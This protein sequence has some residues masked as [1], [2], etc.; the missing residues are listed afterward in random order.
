MSVAGDLVDLLLPVRCL[1]CGDRVPEGGRR[2]PVCARCTARIR[3]L[4]SPRC[5]RCDLPRGTR[6][7]GG[8]ACPHCAEWPP[9]LVRARCLTALAPPTDDLLH[10]LKYEGW[11]VVAAVLGRRLAHLAPKADAVVAVPTTPE[12]E[13]S[14]GYNQAALLAHEV[15]LARGIPRLDAL[16]RRAGRGS[17]IALQAAD[18]RAN[19]EDA[20]AP[21]PAARRLPDTDHVILVDDVLT[22][23]ATASAAASALGGLGVRSVT[24]LAVARTL[25][26]APDGLSAA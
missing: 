19:V 16:T 15:A 7:S 26:R 23:G 18:R 1:G 3:P 12:R 25:P 6:R 21:G 5:P 8:P 17:Q 2:G 14:R 9:V 11:P 22:T 20:F 4:P 10:A 13:R 24:L